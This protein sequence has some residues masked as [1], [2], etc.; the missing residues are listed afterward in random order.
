MAT[1]RRAWRSLAVISGGAE[2]QSISAANMLARMAWRYSGE[3]ASI[4][5]LRDVSLRLVEHQLREIRAQVEAGDRVFIA[6]RSVSENPAAESVAREAD[7]LVLCVALG[8]TNVKSARRTVE[9]IGRERFL[10]CLLVDP[11]I[12]DWR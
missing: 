5:D 6:L 9:A 1:R 7:A 4:F 2:V 3:A 12:P 8:T 10:G 11:D